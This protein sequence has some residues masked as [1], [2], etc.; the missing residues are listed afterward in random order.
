M[1]AEHTHYTDADGTVWQ[2][3]GYG[4]F[5]AD[6]GDNKAGTRQVF[7]YTEDHEGPKVISFAPDEWSMDDPLD[8]ESK[9]LNVASSE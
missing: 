6:M 5:V 4:T 9:G 2:I 3:D 1:N 8:M 7:L